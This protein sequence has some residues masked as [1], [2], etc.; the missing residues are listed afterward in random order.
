MLSFDEY[1]I[2]HYKSTQDLYNQ[3][4]PLE[5]ITTTNITKVKFL[6][7]SEISQSCVPWWLVPDQSRRS[8]HSSVRQPGCFARRGRGGCSSVTPGTPCL[9]LSVQLRRSAVATSGHAPYLRT[10]Q[11]IKTHITMRTSSFWLLFIIL[12]NIPLWNKIYKS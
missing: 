1:S 7:A 12:R 5:Q 10:Q 9:T 3:I 8:W 11:V 6:S 2:A 4:V